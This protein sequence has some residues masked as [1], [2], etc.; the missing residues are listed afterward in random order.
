MIRLEITNEYDAKRQL[1][2]M[3][4]WDSHLI[5]FAYDNARRHNATYG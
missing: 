3:T 2:G 5:K 4:D 1:I